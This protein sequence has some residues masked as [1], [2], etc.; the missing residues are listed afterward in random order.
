MIIYIEVLI[1]WCC[2]CNMNM[3]LRSRNKINAK[4]KDDDAII[5]KSIEKHTHVTFQL[6]I[7]VKIIIGVN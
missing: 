2:L 6:E 3:S 5:L 1:T 7:M 4:F